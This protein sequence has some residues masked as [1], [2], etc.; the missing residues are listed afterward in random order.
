MSGRIVRDTLW[1]YAG[2]RG[3][4]NDNGVLDCTKPEDGSPCAT[5]LTQRFN[6]FKTTYQMN[7]SNRLIGYYQWSL[8]VNDTGASSLVAWG[9]R[10]HQ[11]FIGKMGKVEWQGT[12]RNNL[13]ANALVGYWDFDSLQ[14]GTILRRPRSTSSP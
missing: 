3:R 12:P 2:I 1:F 10:F 5:E 13:V 8:K 4:V 7:A 14:T 6:T 9:S 11:D